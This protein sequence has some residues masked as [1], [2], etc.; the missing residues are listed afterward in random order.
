MAV[1]PRAS[2][3]PAVVLAAVLIAGLGAWGA[4]DAARRAQ[5]LAAPEAERQKK[6]EDFLGGFLGSL[7]LQSSA[8]ENLNSFDK[9]LVVAYTFLAK[10]YAKRAGNLLLIRPRV[11][12]EKALDL[13]QEKGKERKYPVEFDRTSTLPSWKRSSAAP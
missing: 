13:N 9:N 3:R 8:V 4:P 11:L 2:A 7:V 10:N 12:G 6:L 5:L 1:R